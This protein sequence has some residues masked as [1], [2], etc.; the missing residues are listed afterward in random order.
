[1]TPHPDTTTVDTAPGSSPMPWTPARIRALGPVTDVVTAGAI[2]GL[3]RSVAYDL[4]AR[5][6]FPVAVIRAGSRY[7]IPVAALLTALHIPL[8]PAIA[9]PT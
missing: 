7:R 1:M 8:E 2:L 9:D 5:G 4:A 3:S 6:Q